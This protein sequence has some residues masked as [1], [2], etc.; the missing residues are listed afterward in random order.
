MVS[1]LLPAR[2]LALV[3]SALYSIHA[4]RAA[5]VPWVEGLKR[6]HKK[7]VNLQAPIVGGP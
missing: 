6:Q 1:A 5:E 2:H 7:I 4:K 3:G